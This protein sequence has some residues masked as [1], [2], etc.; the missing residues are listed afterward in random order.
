MTYVPAA[1][2]PFA[3]TDLPHVTAYWSVRWRAAVPAF[4]TGYHLD[5]AGYRWLGYRTDEEN[6]GV[7]DEMGQLVVDA[8]SEA[9]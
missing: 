5:D 7:V 4:I 8:L 2:V 9:L 3:T 6:T 1:P